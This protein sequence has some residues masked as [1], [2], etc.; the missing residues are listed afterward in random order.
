MR[1]ENQCL[2][3]R[4]NPQ[5]GTPCAHTDSANAPNATTLVSRRINAIPHCRRVERKGRLKTMEATY[6]RTR[7]I[8]G[9]GL[10]Q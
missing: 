3:D 10:P 6:E 4:F 7:Y 9:A 8:I 5:S 1:T 2:Q